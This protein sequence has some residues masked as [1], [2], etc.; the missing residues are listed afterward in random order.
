MV[1][2]V[3]WTCILNKAHY[4]GYSNCSLKKDR[5]KK[6]KFVSF[7][8]VF[9]SFWHGLLKFKLLW[10]EWWF[11]DWRCQQ[12]HFLRAPAIPFCIERG[13]VNTIWIL[14]LR[15]STN[16]KPTVTSVKKGK[17]TPG[18]LFLLNHSIKLKTITILLYF[19]FSVQMK[20]HPLNKGKPVDSL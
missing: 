20:Q 7:H 15:S 13:H 19:M 9:L 14:N 2:K 5:K 16:W 10:R 3:N 6:K 18:K 12:S 4:L 17:Q 1:I 8:V 11:Q